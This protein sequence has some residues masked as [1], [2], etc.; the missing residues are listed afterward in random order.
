M[1]KTE[2]RN[3]SV[4]TRG[5]GVGISLYLLFNTCIGY[6]CCI[7]DY[8]FSVLFAFIIIVSVGQG[9]WAWVG[10]VLCFRVSLGCNLCLVAR[11]EISSEAQMGKN[12]LQRS[13]GLLAESLQL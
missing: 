5:L 8:K 3:L 6:Q 11:A 7:T 10:W 9:V 13:L 12:L 4:G 1:I 2:T